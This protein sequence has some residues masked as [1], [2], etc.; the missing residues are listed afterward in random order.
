MSFETIRRIHFRLNNGTTIQN[1]TGARLPDGTVG[2]PLG[3]LS[4]MYQNL[5]A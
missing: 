5:G 3:S 1:A 2:P 4:I